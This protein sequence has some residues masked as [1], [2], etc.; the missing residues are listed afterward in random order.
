MRQIFGKLVPNNFQFVAES[1]GRCPGAPVPGSAFALLVNGVEGC[2]EVTACVIPE[3]GLA[4]PS[5]NNT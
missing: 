2:Y 3:W 5:I 1:G 4:L